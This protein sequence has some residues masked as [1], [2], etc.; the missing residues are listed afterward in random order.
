MLSLCCLLIITSLGAGFGFCSWL[1]AVCGVFG[2]LLRLC[3]LFAVNSVGLLV[4]GVLWIRLM[5]CF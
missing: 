1:L 2:L 5:V 4:G 3:L